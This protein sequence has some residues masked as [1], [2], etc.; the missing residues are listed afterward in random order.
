MTE[1]DLVKTGVAGLDEILSSGIP[2]G[3]VILLEGWVGSGKTRLGVGFIYRGAM[4]FNEPGLIVVFEVSPDKI[5]R[6]ALGLGWD[7][8]ELEQSN[9][10]KI[11]FTSR[12]VLR[13]ELQQAD[14][15]LLEEAAKIG[16]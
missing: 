14:S 9:R 10:I 7:L 15:V 11:V 12:D 4:Q 5:M 8:R 13:Q 1:G 16:A 3:N 2:R 6:D